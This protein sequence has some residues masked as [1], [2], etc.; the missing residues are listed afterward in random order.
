MRWPLELKDSISK[1]LGSAVGC[2]ALLTPKEPFVPKYPLIKAKIKQSII[3]GAY[4][5]GQ[6]LP[7][8]YALASEFGVSRM[9]LR[10]AIDELE[11]EGYL[12]RVQGAGTFPTKQRFVQG[13]FRASFFSELE[14]SGISIRVLHALEM[15]APVELARTLKI[16][17]GETVF[18]LERLRVEDERPLSLEKRYIVAQHV[19][20]FLGFDLFYPSLHDLLVSKGVA[21]TEVEQT[22]RAIALHPADAKLLQVPAHSPAF[23]LQRTASSASGPVSFTQYFFRGDAFYLQSKYKL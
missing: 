16:K 11:T 10:R 19:Q 1:R 15:P 13:H 4:P 9:T 21:L 17:A 8:E 14:R 6:A 22:L 7:N 23:A 2:L 20:Q 12:Y 18:V 3:S 5:Q